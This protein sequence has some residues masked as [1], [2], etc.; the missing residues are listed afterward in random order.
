MKK[1]LSIFLIA[2]A[3]VV[4]SACG[5]QERELVIISDFAR[6]VS[7]KEIYQNEI[8]AAF[9][10]EHNV[11]I[12]FETTSQAAETFDKLDT[13]QR[14]GNHTVDLV[15]SHF[16][17]MVSY[18][19]AGYIEDSSALERAMSDRTFL[20]TFDGTTKV[21]NT[22]YFFPINS[23]VYLTYANV[24]AFDYLP[25]GLTRQQVLD[26]NY[27]WDQFVAWANNMPGTRVF[28]KGSP[29]GQLLYQVAGKA[30]AHGGTFPNLNDAGN[31][32]AWANVYAM[33][34]AIHPESLTN[35]TSEQLMANGS[36]LLAFELMAPLATAYSAAPA[37]YEVFPGPKG[38][39]GSAGSIIGGHGIGVAKNAPNRELAEEFIKWFTAPEQIIYAALGTIPTIQEASAALGNEPRDVVLRKGLETVANARVEGLQ[40][41]PEFTD[42][43][44]LKGTYDRIFEEILDG[45]INSTNLLA[46]LNEEQAIL[47]SL[48]R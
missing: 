3:A 21:G 37:R 47:E 11:S 26:G 22:R 38:M 2:I 15:I 32:Q 40:M 29:N 27:T 34:D 48:R 8:F 31:Q 36:T 7:E 44:A 42:W 43:S 18:L 33:K 45:R 28:F 41:I 9:E 24:E 39:T 4:L 16:G 12:R 6:E 25:D 23:D 35:V 20:T 13:E 19:N 46:R 5:E 30:L 1:I 10:A 14:A 17:N